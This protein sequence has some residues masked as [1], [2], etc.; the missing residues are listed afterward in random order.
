M[1]NLRISWKLVAF[2]VVG[3]IGSCFY[4]TRSKAFTQVESQYLPAVQLVASQSAAVKVS[5]ITGN[6]LDITITIFKGNG[7]V[8][9]RKSETLAPLATAT[10]MITVKDATR[11]RA[12]VA[13]GSAQS[14]VSDVLVFDKTTGEVSSAL[15]GLLLP[16]VQ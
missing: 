2:F 6:D 11:I 12:V 1:K 10:R 16:A 15:I 5:N 3:T 9:S 14:A 7:E 4:V 13:L 8:L